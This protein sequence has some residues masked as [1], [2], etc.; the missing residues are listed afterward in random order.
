MWSFITACRESLPCSPCPLQGK[1]FLAA[2]KVVALWPTRSPGFPGDHNKTVHEATSFNGIEENTNKK[3]VTGS[4]CP[5]WGGKNEH[6]QNGAKN[7]LLGIQK[8]QRWCHETRH[9]ATLYKGIDK[10][11]T[12]N[13][14][15]KSA[16]PEQALKMSTLKNRLKKHF[17][18]PKSRNILAYYIS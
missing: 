15:M 12:K 1:H 4:P 5:E 3:S 13:T 2:Q 7:P 16:R 10:K 8:T 11:V 14:V 17:F 9:E 6:P 18:C